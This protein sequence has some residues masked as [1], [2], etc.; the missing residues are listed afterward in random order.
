MLYFV[1][2]FGHRLTPAGFIVDHRV[3]VDVLV[4]GQLIG[5]VGALIGGREAR[6]RKEEISKLARAPAAP[7]PRGG[8][9]GCG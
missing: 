7:P 4:T 3:L 9:V 2:I 5:F 6:L 1:G 8:P